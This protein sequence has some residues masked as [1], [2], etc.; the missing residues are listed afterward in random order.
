LWKL[1]L[2]RKLLAINIVVV[3]NIKKEIVDHYFAVAI[4]LEINMA[5]NIGINM[6]NNMA[7]EIN[8]W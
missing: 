7:I 3:I 6:T 5:I 2:R 4:N 8:V 1:I